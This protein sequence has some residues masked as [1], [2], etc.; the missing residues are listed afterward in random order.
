MTTLE[1]LPVPRVP[2]ADRRPVPDP[3]GSRTA[4]AAV[5]PR[6][7]ERAPPRALAAL[8]GA[9]ARLHDKD[10]LMNTA[11]GATRYASPPHRRS[12]DLLDRL[13]LRVGVALVAWSRRERRLPLSHADVVA[14]RRERADL[15][16][17]ERRHQLLRL[18][19]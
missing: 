9:P 4:L 8:F 18:P 2:R 13:A 6:A 17:R 3:R 15:L 1:K 7:L 19:R 5:P 11:L 16:E 10:T 12:A 14:L